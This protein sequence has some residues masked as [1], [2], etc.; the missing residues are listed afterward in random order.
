MAE[1]R[2]PNNLAKR[3]YK[4]SIDGAGMWCGTCPDCGQVFTATHMSVS[5]Q[6]VINDIERHR[7]AEHQ[8]SETQR[9]VK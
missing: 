6:R 2:R 3:F 8:P 5:Q 9:Y 1:P 4:I 7:T